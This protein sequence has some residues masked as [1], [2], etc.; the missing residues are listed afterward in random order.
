MQ[1]EC[2][3][4]YCYRFKAGHR[5]LVQLLSSDGPGG[6]LT[7]EMDQS[8]VFPYAAPMVVCSVGGGGSLVVG[9]VGLGLVVRRRRPAAAA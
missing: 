7:L 5:E 1:A 2:G 3:D 8:Y 6:E 4:L 9:L